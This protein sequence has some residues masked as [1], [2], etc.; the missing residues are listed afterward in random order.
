MYTL[1]A[2]C[3]YDNNDFVDEVQHK[4][5]NSQLML[6]Y[7]TQGSL[8]CHLFVLYLFLTPMRLL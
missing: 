4:Y 3:P 6:E 7:Q 5:E 2:I 1:I 8:L